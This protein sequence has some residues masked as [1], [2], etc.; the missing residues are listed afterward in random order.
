[1]KRAME[2][3]LTKKDG[4]LMTSSPDGSGQAMWLLKNKL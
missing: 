2:A 3:N 1:M 4:Y